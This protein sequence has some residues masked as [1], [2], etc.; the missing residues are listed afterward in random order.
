MFATGYLLSTSGADGLASPMN[1]GLRA[2][3]RR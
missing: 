2:A 3:A 1:D